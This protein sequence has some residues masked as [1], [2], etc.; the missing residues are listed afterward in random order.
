MSS[1]SNPDLP[2]Y[3]IVCPT[4]VHHQAANSAIDESTPSLDE[5]KL[6]PRSWYTVAMD[7]AMNEK[8]TL[9]EEN[10]TSLNESRP[11]NSYDTACRIVAIYISFG[12]LIQYEPDNGWCDYPHVVLF[13]DHALLFGLWQILVVA[14]K[15]VL[16][17]CRRHSPTYAAAGRTL[18]RFVVDYLFLF[19]LIV[20]PQHG[21]QECIQG[22]GS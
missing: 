4:P 14:E 3:S 1:K 12:I 11:P 10:A 22:P 5:N 15:V 17:D 21:A 8:V 20:Y 6:L 9:L 2:R 16:L 18:F 13:L 7:S 19:A